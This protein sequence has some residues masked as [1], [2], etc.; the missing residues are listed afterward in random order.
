MENQMNEALYDRP[1]GMG[2][3]RHL[4]HQHSDPQTVVADAGMSLEDKRALLADWASDARAV[5]DH[6]ALRQL[7]SG[8]VVEIDSILDALKGLDGI[9]DNQTSS[10]TRAPDTK[11]L[12]RTA[13]EKS[14]LLWR[15][16][17]DDD[18]DPPPCPATAV[19]WRPLPIL[20]AP[21]RI[22]A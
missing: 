8:V 15:F 22:A 16:W 12:G 4:Q 19:P 11:H 1:T 21:G 17:D 2:L 10:A 14:P 18:D 20:D 9:H 13:A 3:V 6:P 5:R 7:N